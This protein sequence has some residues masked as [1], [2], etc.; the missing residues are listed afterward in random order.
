MEESEAREEKAGGRI[1]L[2]EES[3]SSNWLTSFHRDLTAGAL[4]GGVVHTIVAPIERAK[5]LLQTQESNIA[6]LTGG[7]HRRFK[8]MI[9]CIARTAR[10]EGILSLWRGNG[11]SV[12][13]YYPSV[14]LNFSLKVGNQTSFVYFMCLVCGINV[15]SVSEVN[16]SCE[17]GVCFFMMDKWN[18]WFRNCTMELLWCCLVFSI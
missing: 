12:I 17:F 10:E 9:D 6:I 5:L 16:E 15:V 3:A 11:S 8:G 13:R 2:G 7:P 18:G 14:S 1:L 4:M